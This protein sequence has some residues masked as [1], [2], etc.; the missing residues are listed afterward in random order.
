MV[1]NDKR[2]QVLANAIMIILALFCVIPIILLIVSSITKES[3]LINYGYSFIPRQ[4]DF[5][6]YKY[7]LSNTSSV[8]RA[9]GITIITTVIGTILNVIITALFA[10]PLSRKDL[11]GRNFFS[12]FL[13]FTML[14]GGGLV[15]TYMM[16]TQFFHVK[17]TLGGLIFPGLL[18]GAFNVIMMRTY[19]ST[20]IPEAVIEAARID[21]ADEFATLRKI[22]LPMS[23]PIIATI[24]LL[25]SLGYWNDW[26]NGLI[27]IT[28]DRMY[29]IQVLLNRMLTDIQF[30]N[31]SINQSVSSKFAANLPST[32]LTMAV[33]VLGA[34]PMLIAYPFFQKYLVKGITI[35]AVKG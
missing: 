31:S 1:D 8:M 10:Y 11:P 12:F 17:N 22:V 21:G 29:G 34:L 16:W 14:F 7:L 25:V 24:S 35:G 3:A 27:Y 6:A 4:I 2:F 20:N 9:Y 13:F 23:L 5:S 30:M 15:P 18:M 19:F 28:D 26:M 33:A 32:A